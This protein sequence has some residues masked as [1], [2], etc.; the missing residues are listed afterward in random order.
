MLGPDRVTA[1]IACREAG[2][3][4][5]QRLPALDDSL[6]RAA[7]TSTQHA[8]RPPRGDRAVASPPLA[9]EAVPAG[10]GAEPRTS[11]CRPEQVAIP[12]RQ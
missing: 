7:G 11:F 6:P 1:M 2:L 5:H 3:E 10:A 4:G 8:A 12:V 9:H